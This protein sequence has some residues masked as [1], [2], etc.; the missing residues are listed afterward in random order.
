MHE[1]AVTENILEISQ[2]H[3]KT[4]GAIQV[5]DIH[6]IVGQLASIVDDSVQFYWDMIAKGTIC[7]N[8]KLHFERIPAE[9]SCENCQATYHLE[10]ELTPCPA[11]GS[12]RVKILSGN[13]FRV[14]S[15]E[16][17]K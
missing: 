9:L 1:L 10:Q 2:N 13:E 3:A 15:I 6:I 4:A 14:D 5:T 8:A 11:C 17:T 12:N 7:E 16:I